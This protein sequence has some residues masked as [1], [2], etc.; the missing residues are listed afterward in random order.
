MGRHSDNISV[1][2][3]AGIK[4]DL[5]RVP[6][7]DGAYDCGGAYWGSPSDLWVARC[8]DETDVY[9]YFVRADSR[10]A[11]MTL[12]RNKVSDAEFSPETGSVIEQTIEFL[13]TYLDQRDA[14]GEEELDE[15]TDIMLPELVEELDHIRS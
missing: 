15:D 9:W 2:D 11:A 6:L 5:E 13:Q 12:V 1:L 8:E 3:G 14:M 7:V 10:E 4:F